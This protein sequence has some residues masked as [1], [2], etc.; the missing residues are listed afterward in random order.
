VTRKWLPHTEADGVRARFRRRR[1]KRRNS[2]DES[3]LDSIDVG[4]GCIDGDDFFVGLAVGIAVLVLVVLLVALTPLVLLGI[5]ALVF[6]LVTIASVFGRVVLRR[7]W[8]VVA[9]S[10]TG[11]VRV[12]K[13][14]GFRDAGQLRDSL[15]AEFGAGFDP[16]PDKLGA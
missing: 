12:W 9:T 13:V 1:S 8:K 6:V 5:E 15:A 16:H 3:W 7:P 10:I 14:R 4:S 11:E 2:N